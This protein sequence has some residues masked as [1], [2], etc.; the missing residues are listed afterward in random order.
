M[1]EMG[2]GFV[3]QGISCLGEG[4]DATEKGGVLVGLG[5]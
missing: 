1:G 5:C 3:C 2:L 4:L